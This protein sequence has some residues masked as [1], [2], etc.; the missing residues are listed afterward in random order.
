[1]RVVLREESKRFVRAEVKAVRC[2]KPASKWKE[3][4]GISTEK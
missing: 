1:M 3:R 2:E 4:E